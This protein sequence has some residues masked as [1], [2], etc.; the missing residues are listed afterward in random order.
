MKTSTCLK[1][2]YSVIVSDSRTVSYYFESKS[3]IYSLL[4]K[5]NLSR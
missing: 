4:L 1:G 3:G 2:S 5:I